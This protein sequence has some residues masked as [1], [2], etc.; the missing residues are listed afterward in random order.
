MQTV[1]AILSTTVLRWQALAEN[2]PPELLN[3]PPAPGEWS[4]MQCLAHLLDTE[5]Q[6]FPVRVRAFLAGQDF[7]AFNPDAQGTIIDANTQPLKLVA[8]FAQLRKESL[9]LLST[10]TPAD[11]PRVATHAELGPVRLEQMLNEWAGHDLDHTIQAERAVMQPFI[12]ASGPW[13]K[14][15][16]ANLIR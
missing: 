11:L 6:V 2:L 9:V 5:R 1:I 13:Q 14:Y 15:F 16:A 10:L 4:A 3:R 12:Q 7:P 8:L